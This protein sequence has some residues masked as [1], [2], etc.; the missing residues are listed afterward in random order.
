[1]A[2]PTPLKTACKSIVNAQSCIEKILVGSTTTGKYAKIGSDMRT[3]LQDVIL[4]LEELEEGAAHLRDSIKNLIECMRPVNT[5][6]SKVR[7]NGKPTPLTPKEPVT[8]TDLPPVVTEN[9][10][11][12]CTI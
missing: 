11:E 12:A 4:E 6:A 5:E 1:M 10:V 7:L 8:F 3:D 9:N 2:K